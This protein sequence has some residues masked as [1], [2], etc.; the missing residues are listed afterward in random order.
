M[1]VM[2]S[3]S[4]RRPAATVLRRRPIRRTIAHCTSIP[5]ATEELMIAPTLIKPY[6]EVLGSDGV[7]SRDRRSSGTPASHQ[8]DEGHQGCRRRRPLHPARV[9]RPRRNEGR[10]DS[11]PPTKPWRSGKA[12]ADAHR[13]SRR[14]RRNADRQRGVR[15]RATASRQPAHLRSRV[16]ASM[17]GSKRRSHFHVAAKPARSGHSPAA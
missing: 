3:F 5:R 15:V 16:A 12:T 10:P 14:N 2:L 7:A 17:R 8:A 11:S 9:D 1:T 6:M 4:R 13:S